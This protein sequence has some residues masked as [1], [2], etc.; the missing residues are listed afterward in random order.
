MAEAYKALVK[1]RYD[2]KGRQITD[3][4]YEDKIVRPCEHPNYD[5]CDVVKDLPAVS[6]PWLLE[7]GLIEPVEAPKKPE[8]K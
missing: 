2:S 6:L 5:G 3:P 7:Q 8:G 1:L 4:K